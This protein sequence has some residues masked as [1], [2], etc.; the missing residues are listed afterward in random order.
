MAE[1]Q[2]MSQWFDHNSHSRNFVSPSNARLQRR[3]LAGV[4][5][6]ALL[7]P[8]AHHANIDLPVNVFP[9]F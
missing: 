2:V 4:R 5:C 3:P 8:I 6:K 9:L 7:G 1:H